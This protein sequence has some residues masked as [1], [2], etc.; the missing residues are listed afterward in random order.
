M[1]L[2]D[3]GSNTNNQGPL[4][5]SQGIVP[6]SGDWQAEITTKSG[7]SKDLHWWV[8]FGINEDDHMVRYA[9]LLYF[10]GRF[11]DNS[12][13]PIL[14]TV[15]SKQEETGSFSVTIAEFKNGTT[16]SYPIKG[17]FTS[18]TK[19]EGTISIDGNEYRWTAAPLK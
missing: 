5:E 3:S 10:Y 12:S 11:E 1:L 7:D 17:I 4:P 6:Q 18:E 8:E 9:R 2:G 14:L 19:A 13:V 15:P 16:H